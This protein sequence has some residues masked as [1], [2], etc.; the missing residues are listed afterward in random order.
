[1]ARGA[2]N[3]RRIA[4]SWRT[5]GDSNAERGPRA[6]LYSAQDHETCMNP[7]VPSQKRKGIAL[8]AWIFRL[9]FAAMLLAL[10]IWGITLCQEIFRVPIGPGSLPSDS[11]FASLGAWATWIL[12][13]GPVAAIGLVM[14][15]STL[16]KE[17]AFDRLASWLSGRLG[18][19]DGSLASTDQAGA[20][21]PGDGTHHPRGPENLSSD[22]VER[23]TRTATRTAVVLGALAGTS[24]LSIGIFGL[25]CLRISGLYSG[26]SIYLALITGRLTI[27]L[28]LLSG[29][30]VLLGLAILQRTFR[31]DRNSWLLPLRVFTYMALKRRQTEQNARRTRPHPSDTKPLP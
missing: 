26:S 6:G 2:A 10:S 23:L 16:R 14:T 21:V 20:H 15:W 1:M 4:L 12:F 22:T 17:G 30:S 3:Q 9:T 13:F 5:H 31:A 19:S 25:I 8:R 28:A 27:T 11:S 29:M 18:R 7:T 24:L